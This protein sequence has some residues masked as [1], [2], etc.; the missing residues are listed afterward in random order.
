[1]SVGDSAGGDLSGWSMAVRE[2]NALTKALV[3][4]SNLRDTAAAG[5]HSCACSAAEDSSLRRRRRCSS[6]RS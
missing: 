3:L 6:K 1:M 2:S 4:D 5:S